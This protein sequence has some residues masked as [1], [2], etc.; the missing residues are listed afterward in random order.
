MGGIEDWSY[1]VTMMLRKENIQAF[2]LESCH[3]NVQRDELEQFI[4]RFD[5]NYQQWLTTHLQ[6]VHLLYSKMPFVLFNNRSRDVLYT[7]EILK[8]MYPDQI[9]IITVLHCDFS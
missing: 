4:I 9:K 3:Q 7:A 5:R 6:L 8:C 1:D 2:V